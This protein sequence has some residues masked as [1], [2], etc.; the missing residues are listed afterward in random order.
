MSS[1]KCF[2]LVF[3]YF[4]FAS[5]PLKITEY[6]AHE[7]ESPCQPPGGAKCSSFSL[8][9]ALKRLH[10]PASP[11][12]GEGRTLP[13]HRAAVQDGGEQREQRPLRT[14]LEGHH[15]GVRPS[16]LRPAAHDP[17]LL[18]HLC[19]HGQSQ[20][21]EVHQKPLHQQVPDHPQS[22]KSGERRPRFLSSS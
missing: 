13:R 9:R 20:E 7:P 8:V 22:G 19:R 6:L 12:P 1:M 21:A 5:V 16:R 4:F 3:Y 17:P 11:D 18:C 10:P 14:R 15:A 2:V